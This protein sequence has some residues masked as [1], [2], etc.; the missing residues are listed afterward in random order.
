MS[1]DDNLPPSFTVVTKSVSLNF[2]EPSEP[3][4]TCNGTD[5]PLPLSVIKNAVCH[6]KIYLHIFSCYLLLTSN[7]TILNK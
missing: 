4:Q 3:V 2:L 7:L 5:L 6:S 1:K